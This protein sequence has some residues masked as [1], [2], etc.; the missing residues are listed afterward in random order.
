[1]VVCNCLAVNDKVVRESIAAGAST[2]D[3]VTDSCEAGGGCGRCWPVIDRML[4]AAGCAP[5]PAQ[6]A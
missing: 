4:A 6:A 3:E 2:L 5:G 1:M